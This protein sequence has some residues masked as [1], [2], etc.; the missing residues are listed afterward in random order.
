MTVQST[1]R[2]AHGPRPRATRASLR[3]VASPRGC[4]RRDRRRTLGSRRPGAGN[5]RRPDVACRHIDEIGLIARTSTTRASPGRGV[6]A[7]TPDPRRPTRV[8][9][10][11]RRS[12]A[13]RYR[14]KPIHCARGG[15][16][17]GPELRDLHI[18]IGRRRR[19]GARQR[20]GRRRAVIVASP[21]RRSTTACRPFDGQPARLFVGWR[22]HA[23]GGGR[24]RAGRRRRRRRRQEEVTL[25]ALARRL[26]R[27]PDVRSSST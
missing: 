18:D 4:L 22:R 11:A 7:G 3:G 5:R 9:R 26:P 23:W 19:G 1:S 8:D 21:S 2:P 25:G 13:G 14:R 17:E 15:Q 27:A 10:D 20:P 24:R 6:G 16:E 12:R